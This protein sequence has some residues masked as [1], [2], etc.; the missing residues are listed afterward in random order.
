MSTNDQD[1]S[2]LWKTQKSLTE[3]LE[4]IRH[5]DTEAIRQ[6]DNEKRTR[7]ATLHDITGLPFDRPVQ[8]TATELVTPGPAFQKYLREHG[9][10]L[11]ALRLTP[12]KE[13]L[14]K[15]RMRGKTVTDAYEWFKTLDIRP[16]DYRVDFLGQEK[17]SRWATIFIVN[18]HGIY[19]EII[20]GKHFQL[21]QGL[22]QTD[23]PK[24]FRYDFKTWHIA[25]GSDEALAHVQM[26]AKHLHV[27]D[28]KQ[29][30]A[31]A[32]RLGG[33]F[34]HNYL[35]GYFETVDS[36][37]FGTWFLDY[38]PGLGKMY[39]DLVIA[40]SVAAQNTIVSGQTGAPGSAEGPVIIIKPEELNDAGLSFP[41]GGV[42]VCSVTTPQYVPLMQ[43]AAA[44]VT[45][46]GGILSHAAIVAREL[47]V[48][49]IVGTGNATQLL[50]DG[51]R[52]VVDAN[53]GTVT[54][55]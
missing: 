47:K 3:W 46:Q 53:A 25:P 33:T 12:V 22:H 43:K 18:Q 29:R 23:T 7:L 6:E 26:L 10:D 15:L 17:T 37:D 55:S 19:G 50:K 2:E 41:D 31:V 52:V 8:F 35:E 1:F 34:A 39:A 14:P 30:T 16:E 48:P 38:S 27:T 51:R 24:V 21:T 11:C 20:Y 42:L 9:K 28:A 5:A 13:K 44:I 54:S 40:D 45:D 4:D 32:E 49:C 36:E